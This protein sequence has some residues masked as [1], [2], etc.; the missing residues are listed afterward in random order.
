[1]PN[2]PLTTQAYNAKPN[3][4]PAKILLLLAFILSV[5][6]CQQKVESY[7]TSIFSFGTVIEVEVAGINE[8][9]AEQV[10]KTIEEDLQ[11]MHVYW[12]PW[13]AGALS[14]T[15]KLCGMAGTFSAAI[16]V[17]PLIQKAQVLAKQSDNLFNPAIGNLIQLWG[18]QQD[19]FENNTVPDD[20]EIQALVKANPRMSD[21]HIS[22]VRI[23][24]DNPDVRL[25]FGGIAKGFALEKI[26]SNITQTYGVKNMI[27]NA[28]GDLKAI[29]KHGD[30]PWHI[31][32]RDPFSTD[33]NTA[34]ASIEVNSGDSIF[35][36]GNYE[37]YYM[38]NNKRIHHI[39]DPRTGYP[40]KDSMSVTVIHPDATTAD[41]AATALFVAGPKQWVEIAQKMGIEYVLLIDDKQNVY[42]TQAMLD[43]V[44]FVKEPKN[45]LVFRP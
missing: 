28:G 39:I 14:R 26:I 43:R 41:A 10:F 27:I 11:R 21:I 1:M 37:R 32:I 6:A 18:F 9:L 8:K 29:G 4:R 22:G 3:H 25:D 16:S 7:K 34:F 35:T 12:H 45:L 33:K 20:A 13:Q 23:T 17:I 36:S 42:V 19:E 30:R 15:N 2:H 31:G 44:K 24:C 38:A 40:A 5:I